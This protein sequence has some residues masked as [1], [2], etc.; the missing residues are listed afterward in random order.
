MGSKL[1]IQSNCNDLEWLNGVQVNSVSKMR[2]QDGEFLE[3]A[4][5]HMVE[6]ETKSLAICTPHRDLAFVINGLVIPGSDPQ[7]D[8]HWIELILNGGLTAMAL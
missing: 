7:F 4:D 3:I 2:E 5:A 6:L 1:V 8:S